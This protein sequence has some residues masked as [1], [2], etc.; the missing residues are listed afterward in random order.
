MW[1]TEESGWAYPELERF[2]FNQKSQPWTPHWFSEMLAWT[3]Y[4]EVCIYLKWLQHC[5]AEVVYDRNSL[6]ISP[7]KRELP[8]YLTKTQISANLLNMVKESSLKR[9]LNSYLF[10]SWKP[11]SCWHI[12]TNVF[13]ESSILWNF[14]QKA[15]HIGHVGFYCLSVSLQLPL[16]HVFLSCIVTSER[17]W[18]S[19]IILHS[20]LKEAAQ[21]GRS[22]GLRTNRI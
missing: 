11:Y 18:E 14:Q 19:Y 4:T 20:F 3:F 17:P 1:F 9:T 12:P 6:A 21:N 13:T 7:Q 22:F 2:I 15:S 16:F 10:S 8:G 5:S